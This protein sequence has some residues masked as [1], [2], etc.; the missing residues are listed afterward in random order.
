MRKTSESGRVIEATDKEA[1]EI[2]ALICR[3]LE[4]QAG[5]TP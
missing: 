2:E 5:G 4:A 3:Q 1:P